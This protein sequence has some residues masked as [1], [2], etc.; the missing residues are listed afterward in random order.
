MAQDFDA[1]G[2]G[3]PT[4]AH[5]THDYLDLRRGEYGNAPFENT[6][7]GKVEREKIDLRRLAI[8][9]KGGPDR[10]RSASTTGL[11]LSGGGIRS[12]AFNLGALQAL[13]T[14]ALLDGVDYL[15]TVSGGGY[16]G[17]A[18]TATST[19]SRGDPAF[20]FN[21]KDKSLFDDTAA[22]RHIRDYSN[23]LM[24]RG[25]G[26]L[27]AS[28]GIILR[29]LLANAIIVAPFLFLAAGLTLLFYPC[30]A[31]FE[32]LSLLP[33]FLQRWLFGRAPEAEHFWLAPT[34]ALVNV[35]F[36]TIWAIWS[37]LSGGAL[38]ASDAAGLG[39]SRGIFVAVSKSLFVITAVAVAFDLQILILK[40]A[41]EHAMSNGLELTKWV[42]ET[43]ELVGKISLIL[44]PMGALAAFF[45]KNLA[46]IAA[47]AA[48]SQTWRA[49]GKKIAARLALW[50]AALIVPL[51]LA[52]FYLF[53]VLHGL[54]DSDGGYLFPQWFPILPPAKFYL[55][56]AGATVFLALL[57]DPNITS[58]HRLYR[59]RLSKAFLFNPDSSYLFDDAGDRVLKRDLR[60]F[61]PKLS[62][63][64]TDFC[65]YPII[66]ATLN[67]VGSRFANRRGRD[68]DFFVFTP[69]YS[70][71]E[72]TGYV[73]SGRFEGGK[74]GIDL[75]AAMAISGAA[76]SPNMG[77]A[78]VRPLVFT[79]AFLNIRLGYWLLNP[80]NFAPPENP[81]R[82]LAPLKGALKRFADAAPIRL[83]R[84]MF[85][86]ID[87]T[88]RTI[89]LTD[90]GNLENLGLYELLRRRCKLII[91]VD[92]EQDATMSFPSL[93]LLERYA[94]IDFGARITLPWEGIADRC[95][96][97]YDALV[98]AKEEGVDAPRTPGP[99]C[100]VGEI[101]YGGSERGVLV[102]FKSSLS[103]DEKDYIL[104]YKRR[105][106]AFPHES[107]ADQFF[108]EEQFEAYRALGFHVVN[109]FFTTDAQFQVRPFPGK[110]EAET[111]KLYREEILT[112]L[113]PLSRC[114]GSA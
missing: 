67:L 50:F 79:L 101:H 18:L 1:A 75:G 110:T 111:R 9:A 60:E 96:S 73:G 27:A 87:E 16:I 94:R 80:R 48:R 56:A 8:K 14:S 55:S 83:I 37:R 15:S 84:E 70:G 99:H 100:A 114:A 74:A 43:R 42:E 23:Y 57:I 72:A 90:G 19:A 89:Y 24:P 13:D 82:L 5:S 10:T 35:A 12:A 92:A 58:L 49:L 71:S 36:L 26:D 52:A 112:A 45:A 47:N 41:A 103:G 69:E 30:A 98:K 95:R 65:P 4:G 34:L 6:P 104:D 88:S 51:F 81:P 108:T 2:A 66:N 7:I 63:I 93:L 59:E 33:P 85:S 46:Q 32:N 64:G 20:P 29:G 106:P 109:E 76:I 39:S 31:S 107:T 62:E 97:L 77:S 54:R 68:A 17:C 53:L 11:A 105:N 3:A 21:S 44:A 28:I 102:Y 86:Q 78:T 25:A 61:R 22:V 40:L 91:V 38:F 113:K